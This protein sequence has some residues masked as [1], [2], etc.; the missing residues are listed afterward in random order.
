[1]SSFKIYRDKGNEKTLRCLCAAHLY[2]YGDF[3]LGV[4]NWKLKEKATMFLVNSFLVSVKQH[5]LWLCHETDE[6]CRV[7]KQK[8][9]HLS[10]SRCPSRVGLGAMVCQWQPQ[11]WRRRQQQGDSERLPHFHAA[12]PKNIFLQITAQYFGR[13]CH[14]SSVLLNRHTSGAMVWMV[15]TWGGGGS[16]LPRQNT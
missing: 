1:M 3:S 16:F 13:E 12:P 15:Y 11:L 4:V 7:F 14:Q 8:Q 6:S 5:I 9:G 2:H 10:A